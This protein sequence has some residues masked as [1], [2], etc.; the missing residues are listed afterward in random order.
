M[1]HYSDTGKGKVLVFLHGFCEDLRIW[2]EFTQSLESSYRIICPD[3]PG[4]GRSAPTSSDLS[5]WAETLHNLLSDLGVQKAWIIGHS[6]G[7]YVA[8][9]LAERYPDLFQ[10]LVLFHSTALAD[11]D[12]KKKS[13]NRNIRFIQDHGAV[14]FVRQLIPSLF[15]TSVKRESETQLAL[16]IAETQPDQ[17]L[18]NALMAM[19]NRS[20]R[21]GVLASLPCPVLILSGKHDSVLALKEQAE[22]ALLPD[23]C[24]FHVLP[25][26]GH[27]G[28]LEEPETC[29]TFLLEFIES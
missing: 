19:R 28:M 5:L 27:M 22:L 12:E 4:F 23:V 13:R 8:M 18:V 17:G 2:Q 3:L 29:R 6:M 21:S 20:D 26:T 1:L 15:G 9:A 10:G 7:G 16:Q 14:P 25:D 11:N 24:I